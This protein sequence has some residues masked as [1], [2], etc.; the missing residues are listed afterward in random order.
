MR[1]RKWMAVII[2]ICL[3]FSGVFGFVP[4]KAQADESSVA[5]LDDPADVSG[6]DE[7]VSGDELMIRTNP[8]VTDEGIVQDSDDPDDPDD[9]DDTD[10]PDNLDDPEELT[11]E[12]IAWN[13]LAEAMLAGGEIILES[14]AKAPID[15]EPLVVPENTEVT[16]NL[17]GHSI[18][19]YLTPSD[20]S[21]GHVITVNGTLT[22]TDSAGSGTITGGGS[23]TNGGGIVVNGTFTMNGGIITG[24]Y[25]TKRGGGVYVK[26]GTFIMNGGS[27][28]NN[29]A[30]Y[31]GNSQGGGVYI[32]SAATFQM[33]GGSITDNFA[34]GNGGGVFALNTS[35]FEVG[36]AV[37][38][39]GNKKGDY[40]EDSSLNNVYLG[41]G[42]VIKLIADPQG[43]TI[44]ISSKKKNE[45]LT[46]GYSDYVSQSVFISDN[47][48]LVPSLNSGNEIVL[49]DYMPT[50]TVDCDP[51]QGTISCVTASK[52]GR[53]VSV[54]VT[55]ASENY[56]LQSL[57]VKDATDTDV[58]VHRTNSGYAFTMPDSN[59]TITAVFEEIILTDI[60]INPS[61]NGSV[62]AQMNGVNVT[63]AY[64][65]D[66]VTLLVS[67]E[68]GYA[69]KSLSVMDEN[70]SPVELSSD[71]TFT[72]PEGNVT[73]TAEFVEK[74][75]YSILCANDW[76]DFADAVENGTEVGKTWTLDA[77]ITVNRSVGS[78]THPFIGTFDGNNHT[79]TVNLNDTSNQG[80][81]PFRYIQNA[82]IKDLTV[83]GSVNGTTHAAGL[84]G[85]NWRESGDAVTSTIEN[86]TVNTNVIVKDIGYCHM[87]GVLGHNKSASIIM[88]GVVYSGTMYNDSNFAGGLV[89]W[90][91]DSTITL[92]NCLFKGNY[93]GSEEFHPIGCKNAD[94][95]VDVTVTNTYYTVDPDITSTNNQLRGN[96]GEKVVS[97]MPEDGIY[98][99]IIAADGKDYYAPCVFSGV[100]AFYSTTSAVSWTVK[101]GKKRAL[102][103]GTDYTT[104][105]VKD[106]TPVQAVDGIGNY[107]LTLTGEGA[108][109]GSITAEF[110]V[111]DNVPY[112]DASGA[113]MPAKALTDIIFV[114]ED[115]GFED[116]E[117]C[118]DNGWYVVTGNVTI[119]NRIY[120]YGDDVNIILC[121]GATF[122]AE[123]G[124]DVNQV[125]DPIKLTIWSQKNGTGRLIAD[126]SDG[127]DGHWA[128]I[129]AT[130]AVYGSTE[131]EIGTIII[132]GGHIIATGSSGC[133]GMG[134]IGDYTGGDIQI[135]GGTVEATGGNGEV[136]IRVGS[137]GK[138]TLNYEN[139]AKSTRVTS[140]GY[141]GT[142]KLSKNFVDFKTETPFSATDS[143][144]NDELAGK[145]L[146]PSTVGI[147][148]V[149]F[150]KGEGEEGAEPM[151]AEK[152]IEGE[153]FRLPANKFT[154]PE[155]RPFDCW[156][157]VI[158]EEEAI[159][160]SAGEEITVTADVVATA[161][162]LT[163]WQILQRGIN[164]SENGATITLD[165]NITAGPDDVALIIPEGKIIT[166]DL[167]EYTLDRGLSESLVVDGGN[168]ITNNG[169]LTI[170]G[171][172]GMITGGSN[173]GAGGAIYN[174]GAL[175][176]SGGKLIEN[177]ATEAGAVFNK[178]GATM[179]FTDGE[180]SNNCVTK[181]GGGAVVNYGTMTMS[182]GIVTGNHA[183]MNGAG[184]WNGGRMTITGGSI[185]GN[186][187]DTSTSNGGGIYARGDG[188]LY[189][190]GSPRIIDNTRP[191][192]D[193]NNIN[194]VSGEKITITGALG[195]DALIGVK[196]E[197][198]GAAKII[199]TGLSG[200]ATAKNFSSDEDGYV[201]ILSAGGEAVLNT[202]KVITFEKGND[203]AEGTMD[204][205]KAANG[206]VYTL[207]ECDFVFAGHTFAGWSV[208]S[209]QEIKAAGT[210]IY[211]SSDTTLTANWTE[212]DGPAFVSHSIVLS[213]QIGVNFFADL[214]ML[215]EEER[216][217]VT[218]DFTVNGKTVSAVYDE[219]NR[220]RVGGYYGFTCYVNSVQMADVITATLHYG[221]NLIF[222]QEYAIKDYVDYVNA[223][224]DRFD[225]K[226]VALVNSMADYGHY[227]QPFLANTN[228]WTVGTDHVAMPRQTRYRASDVSEVETAVANETLNCNVEGSG[229]KAVTYSLD[230]ESKTTIRLFLRVKEDYEGAVSATIGDTPIDCVK[231]K[232]GRYRVEIK[233]ISASRLSD[234]YSVTVSAGTDFTISLSP[235]AYVKLILQYETTD[236]PRYAAVAIYRY[237]KATEKCINGN[238]E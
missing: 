150:D 54:A 206:S 92:D 199:T 205:V 5:E 175:T 110:M 220:S 136:G 234:T 238:A 223:H 43:S 62:E 79:L 147:Y 18:N 137:K 34:T 179:I 200:R 159:D 176:I 201:V 217:A 153:K 25:T 119:E 36:G 184:F 68:S 74:Q 19:R 218:V 165:R 193:A 39:T 141:S 2:A 202:A 167:G 135:N 83:T 152:V 169:T 117:V 102:E 112:V 7:A 26:S 41:S 127:F 126:C 233:D 114:G 69:L 187:L 178:S 100:E 122:T 181:F 125:K 161:K 208:G 128:G 235:L 228:H 145:T 94:S 53:S 31:D 77:D 180:I 23:D 164:L 4:M 59:V 113:D 82:T 121:D 116:G 230:F 183:L 22:L 61:E 216:E 49:V 38:I 17:N 15:A 40:R 229:I 215:T 66:L 6:P 51:T 103:P 11:A 224:P 111:M 64:T 84:V 58:T 139:P 105:L 182:G 72:M 96:P 129:G 204:P 37:N 237:A 42:A 170:T 9:P 173:S 50:I 118:W 14:N 78:D 80:T 177:K 10:D 168:V 131:G 148:T 188:Q 197:T 106:G 98:K 207:P 32:N 133:P 73:V 191:N 172:T 198:S 149:S 140:N 190:S 146:I 214:S 195:K 20:L 88:S 154:E 65:G 108:Y 45:S 86:C 63:K 85:F 130:T 95:G 225:D 16:L 57:T 213:G 144:N 24:N 134:T 101:D 124:I 142:V 28:A 52:V 67:P 227:L 222:E 70:D 231:Q 33:N 55:P 212:L 138:I 156:S 132:N 109:R 21:E 93:T 76:S 192:G 120:I 35:H 158:G 186:E 115:T 194:L 13:N 8:D 163:F 47:T 185:T 75:P 155:D 90:S 226:V 189:I 151:T 104:E 3:V 81:A 209:S 1:R 203:D 143:A 60:T 91:D 160:V 219:N 123:D 12:E 46:Y 89:G 232:D 236:T 97:E 29:E 48:S 71:R 99:S 196:S 211:V 162:Y 174:A 171:T 210:T 27:I 44:G 166:I 221:E 87:G 107:I 30:D 56:R 157:V